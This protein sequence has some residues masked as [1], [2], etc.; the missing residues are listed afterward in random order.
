M[1]CMASFSKLHHIFVLKT[2]TGWTEGWSERKEKNSQKIFF[3]SEFFVPT[4]RCHKWGC[5][6]VMQRYE[7]CE[8]DDP[9]FMYA[10]TFL[11]SPAIF[12]VC[13]TSQWVLVNSTKSGIKFK[14]VWCG[15]GWSSKKDDVNFECKMCMLLNWDFW[16]W[17]KLWNPLE[18]EL[19]KLYFWLYRS[20]VRDV[21]VGAKLESRWHRGRRWLLL[22]M[23]HQGK[24]TDLQGGLETQRK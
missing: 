13:L 23:H 21:A 1:S 7:K 16:T 4:V 14:S 15:E 5:H 22:W 24:P 2:V 9:F 19:I 17:D 10:R 3:T 8:V 11:F 6:N 12:F 20:T 18:I